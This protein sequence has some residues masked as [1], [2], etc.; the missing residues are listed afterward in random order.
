M[1]RNIFYDF[2]QTGNVK[3]SCKK[4]EFHSSEKVLNELLLFSPKDDDAAV[5]I[6]AYYAATLISVGSSITGKLAKERFLKQLSL[7]CH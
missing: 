5:I 4:F 7:Y 6:R 3:M 1:D 2:F